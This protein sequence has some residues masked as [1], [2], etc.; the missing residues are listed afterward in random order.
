MAFNR[1]FLAFF[2]VEIVAIIVVLW[3]REQNNPY[4]EYDDKMTSEKLDEIRE[5]YIAGVKA[6]IENDTA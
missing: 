4:G 1:I 5:K 2:T 3:R 6:R